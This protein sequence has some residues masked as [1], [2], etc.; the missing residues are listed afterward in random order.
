MAS[1]RSLGSLT[2]DLILKTA[3]YTEGWDK[4]SR[5]AAKRSKEISST[6][7]AGVTGA[8]KT[9]AVFSAGV[10][11]AQQIIQ[12][13]NTAITQAD[14]LDELST[15]LGISTEKLSE[16]GY[17]AKLTG[18]D[19]ESLTGSLTKFSK[20]VAGALDA[21]SSSGKLFKTLGINVRDAQGDL[22]SAES[23]L[24]EVADKFKSLDNVTLETA[25]SMELFGKSG[26]ELLE[27]LNLGSDGLDKFAAKARNLG[28]VITPEQ[29]EAAA[30]FKD[31]IDNLSAAGQGLFT[32][33]SAE[34]LPEL[35][36]L[37]TWASDYVKDGDNAKKAVED[38]RVTV[39]ALA[40]GVRIG[41]SAFESFKES[42][43]L[44]EFAENSKS[45]LRGLVDF[46][47][48]TANAFGGAADEIYA[49]ANFDRGAQLA[50]QRRQRDGQNQARAGLFGN[51][52]VSPNAFQD[53]TTRINPVSFEDARSRVLPDKSLEGQLNR[54]LG[55]SGGGKGGKSEAEK[56][57][58]ALEKRY[59]SLVESLNEQN[60]LVGKNSELERLRY[61]L[62]EG[63]LKGLAPAQKEQLLA[64]QLQLET[65]QKEYDLMKD[66]IDLEDKQKQASDE[67][68]NG[69][70]LETEAL[71]KS[72][73]WHEIV[74]NLIR[75]G[76]TAQSERGK[77]I[78][79]ATT[80]LYKQGE[81]I[82]R[83][84]RLMDQFRQGFVDT[85]VDIVSGSKSAG[86]ALRDF[87]DDM[88]KN[89]TRSIFEDWS[90]Q[91]FGRPGQLGGGSAGGMIQG[92]L[93]A[94]SGGG[95]S[96][97]GGGGGWATDFGSIFSRIFGG[98]RATGGP[99]WDSQA[100]LVGERGPE[101]FIPQTS[102]MIMSAQATRS[103]LG[104]AGSSPVVFNNNNHF[105]GLPGR[106]TMSQHDTELGLK[107]RRQLGR[108]R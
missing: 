72:A 76:V 49:I 68:L 99:V 5:I 81:V 95:A 47:Q 108:N 4:A 33:L 19:L 38:L 50:A 67:V 25:L 21:D 36:K 63:S 75:A 106:Q 45:Q 55:G 59:Q 22:R 82:E 35:T 77:A 80:D 107:I 2:L 8:L 88:A 13:F 40:E 15:R 105:N 23:L 9:L 94:F 91:L 34:L 58:E 69:I 10:V 42:L 104:G 86:D 56:Q 89:I 93:G 43:D 11:S 12:G 100:Y 71:G 20:N 84:I 65:R 66:R 60:A 6:I 37:V 87:F 97:G 1:S 51:Q 53:V 79:K 85:F 78:V 74:N 31:E 32:Q 57:A 92:I 3:G 16:W 48:G 70:K 96:G 18:T 46:I 98:M 61:D 102:G 7:Q 24:P 41:T 30:K 39:A 27:F 52:Y 29:A 101:F 90:D 28:I 62:I 54:M 64:L 26:A 103:V 17:A 83:Q 14:R 44:G 73:L